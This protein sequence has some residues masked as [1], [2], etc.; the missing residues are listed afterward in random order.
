M[1]PAL[2]RVWMGTMSCTAKTAR[3]RTSLL[4]S[5]L[6]D[7]VEDGLLDQNPLE[8]IALKKMMARTAKK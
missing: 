2:V 4:R 7:A 1:T 3:N 8:R 5:V 6:D